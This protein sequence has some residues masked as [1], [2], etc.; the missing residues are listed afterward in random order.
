MLQVGGASIQMRVISSALSTIGNFS[1]FLTG[2]SSCSISSR[3]FEHLDVQK[4][5]RGAIQLNG[6]GSETCGRRMRCRRNSRICSG[7]N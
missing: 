6:A 7:P 1:R 5:E 3:S 4:P 2:R